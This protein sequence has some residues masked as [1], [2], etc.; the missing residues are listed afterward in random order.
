MKFSRAGNMHFS[1]RSAPLRAALKQIVVLIH[2]RP[3]ESTQPGRNAPGW[4]GIPHRS[5]TTTPGA[6]AFRIGK[7]LLAFRT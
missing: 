1:D 4:H 5:T 7:P 2:F 6:A 3:A